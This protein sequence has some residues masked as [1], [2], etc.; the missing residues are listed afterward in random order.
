MFQK[1]LFY[2]LYTPHV[3]HLFWIASC[4]LWLILKGKFLAILHFHRIAH[5]HNR[6]LWLVMCDNSWS[7][8]WL[9]GSISGLPPTNQNHQCLDTHVCFFTRSLQCS[10]EGGTRDRLM[11]SPV[12][13]SGSY[14]CFACRP[15]WCSV[16]ERGLWNAVCCELMCLYS[17]CS[18]VSLSL[19]PQPFASSSS[20]SLPPNRSPSFI[21]LLKE[22][23][24]ERKRNEVER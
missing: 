20:V 6:S 3:K 7:S 2:F 15:V 21:P 24:P 19:S 23:I 13:G 10:G 17:S 9:K 14:R 5:S 16:E 8:L 4:S 12:C 18:N 11:I 22:S 1:F